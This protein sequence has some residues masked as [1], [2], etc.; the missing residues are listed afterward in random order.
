MTDVI[1]CSCRLFSLLVRVANSSALVNQGNSYSFVSQLSK[2]L[3]PL[4]VA[5]SKQTSA[6]PYVYAAY[7]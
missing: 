2:F 1:L 4:T 5:Q 3:W 7:F 6:K